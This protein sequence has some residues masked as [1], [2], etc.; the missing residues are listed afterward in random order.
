MFENLDKTSNNKTGNQEISL[1]A[2]DL[3]L[4]ENELTFTAKYPTGKWGIG[5]FALKEDVSTSSGIDLV[6]GEASSETFGN[7][8][9]GAQAVS[10]GVVTARFDVT[11]SQDLLLS[12]RAYDID[13]TDEVIVKLNGSVFENLD[14]TSN[15]KTG[16]QEISLSASDLVLGENELTF[17]AKYPTGK[18]GIGNFALKEDVSTSS[19]I[20]LVVGEASSETFGNKWSGAQAVSSGVVTA[21]FDVTDTGDLLLSFRAYDIDSTDEVIVKL[22]GSVFENL[23]KTSNNKTGNQEISLSASD[24]VLGENELTFTAKYPTGKWGIGNFALKE[25]VS[26][27]SGIDLVVGEASSETFG[28]K[29]SGAQAV[30]SGVVTARFDVT[31]RIYYCPLEPT[32]LFYG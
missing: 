30:S 19:G 9:S 7:K 12:F 20:D 4:G 22:N 32:T 16:N 5:N 3:V 13:S 8:W 24:L 28:N 25:D 17:T 18:W 10:S 26:T 23:D 27:S 2:S 14:K 21:R 11:D 15:N 31:G 6:V 29:W 1:S